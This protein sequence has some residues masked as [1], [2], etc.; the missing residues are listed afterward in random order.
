MA[1]ELVLDVSYFKYSDHE[2]FDGASKAEEDDQILDIGID[3]ALKIMLRNLLVKLKVS[4]CELGRRLGLSKTE[5][6]SVLNPR[7]TTRLTTLAKC[8]EI[9]GSPL[10][11]SC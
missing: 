8:F 9:L 6:S 11:I 5:I 7:K 10:N 2:I 1:R 4:Q 3:S